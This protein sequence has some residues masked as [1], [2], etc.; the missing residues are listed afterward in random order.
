MMSATVTEALELVFEEN[1]SNSSSAVSSLIFCVL[2]RE[3]CRPLI[4]VSIF[5]YLCGKKGEALTEQI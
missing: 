3:I 2:F 4:S 5:A 1:D